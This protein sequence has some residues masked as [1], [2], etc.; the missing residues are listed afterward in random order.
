MAT[1]SSIGIGSNLQLSDLLD[2]LQKAEQAPLDA[3]NAQAKS[4]QTKLSAYSQVQSVLDA[5]QARRRS[6]PMLPPSAP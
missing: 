5:Y 1:I 6:C 4:Y 3:I 2:Q